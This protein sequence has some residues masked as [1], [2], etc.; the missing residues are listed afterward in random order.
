MAYAR[1]PLTKNTFD[2]IWLEDT[3]PNPFWK[4]AKT[5]VTQGDILN[6]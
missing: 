6:A 3:N 2:G 5:M 1:L 4:K